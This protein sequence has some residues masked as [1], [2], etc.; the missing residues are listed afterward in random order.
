M[1]SF[2]PIPGLLLQV[3]DINALMVLAVAGA[4]SIGDY[5]EAGAVVVLFAIAAWLEEGCG[6]KA[7]DAISAVLDLQPTTA[8][9]AESGNWTATSISANCRV[10]SIARAWR[11]SCELLTWVGQQQAVQRC[12]P[13]LLLPHE[14]ANPSV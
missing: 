8:T 14:A 6:R 9:L 4:L 1:L 7:R 5:L 10:F 2:A 3:L 13:W 12:H 11:H